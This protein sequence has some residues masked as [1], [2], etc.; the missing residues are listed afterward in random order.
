MELKNVNRNGGNVVAIETKTISFFW[1]LWK[2]GLK[3]N[4]IH[5]FSKRYHDCPKNNS[6]YCSPC[7]SIL[8][9]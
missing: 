4:I 7:L 9:E 2:L 6:A 3:L 5:Y 1:E 8:N